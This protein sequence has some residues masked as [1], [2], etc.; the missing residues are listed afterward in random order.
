MTIY[1]LRK[2]AK[3]QGYKLVRLTPSEKPKK[4]D[5]EKC[6]D[7]KWLNTEN[8]CCI[9][10]ECVCPHKWFRTQTAMWKY[11]HNKACKYFERETEVQNEI[12]K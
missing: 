4:A 10:Y 9:G 8:H 5:Y 7:C 2:E 3:K 1:E 12:E 11:K 6:R